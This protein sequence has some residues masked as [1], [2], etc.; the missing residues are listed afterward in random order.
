MMTFDEEGCVMRNI[1]TGVLMVAIVMASFA[2]GRFTSVPHATAAVQ[3]DRFIHIDVMHL[4]S[5]SRDLP[6]LRVD[7]PY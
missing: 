2:I 7:T 1:Y 3:A 6:E 5:V 4:Q